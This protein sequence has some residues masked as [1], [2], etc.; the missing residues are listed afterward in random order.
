LNKIE[1]AQRTRHY[2]EDPVFQESIA[3]LRAENVKKWQKC[4]P[5]DTDTQIECKYFDKAI[6]ELLRE[7]KR[8]IDDGL[9]EEKTIE[10]KR[11]K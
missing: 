5:K 10:R 6:N 8:T 7:F 11:G 4:D 9:M 1:K 3:V 2:C